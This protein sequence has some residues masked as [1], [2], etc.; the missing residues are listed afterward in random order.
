MTV[1]RAAGAVVV[2]SL[3]VAG[4]ARADDAA[5]LQ[6]ILN[7]QVVTTASTTAQRASVAPALSATITSEDLRLYG[8]HTL[9]EA[10]QFFGLG[11]ETADPLRTPDVGSLG[12]LF[13]NDNGKHFLLLVNGH[14]M[15]D[16]LYGA[17]FFD[18][19][20]G[21][22][23]DLID[24]IEI[25]VGPGSVLYGSNAMMGVVNVITKSASDDKGVH[26][27]GEYEPGRTV[28]ASAGTGFTFKLFGAPSELTFAAQY[29]Q[30]FGPK[31]D[32]GL[33]QFP[34]TY[35]GE[36]IPISFGKNL[37]AN[38]WGG[39]VR[40]AY[41]EQTPSALLRLRVGD[42]EVNLQASSYRRGVPYATSGQYVEFD[43]P[44]SYL[45]DRA[46]RLDVRHQATISAL[47]QLTSRLYA[48]SVDHQ[49]RINVPGLLA[50]HAEPWVQ[51]YD[52]GL[53]R[54]AGI[55]ERLSLNWLHDGSLVTLVGVDARLEEASAK[56]D[57]LD[58]DTRA[59]LEATVG[60]IDKH[61]TLVAPYV[62]QTWSPTNWLDLNA[63][64]RLDADSRYDAVLSPRGAIAIRP[65]EKGVLKAD[66]AQAFRAPTWS[67]TSLANYHFAPSGDLRPET[68]RS[69]SG[70]IEQRF[71]TQRVL[72]G[73][74]RSWWSNL[75][76]SVPLSDAER[77]ML[78]NE[79]K[80]PLVVT[81]LS[82]FQNVASIDNYGWNA[83]WEGSSANNDLRF[84]L[85]VTGAF[86]RLNAGAGPQP[87]AVSP[88]LFGNA[89]LAYVFGG[90]VPTPALVVSFM[91]PRP[92]DAAQP[93]GQP[94]PEAPALADLRLTLGGAVP[95]VPGLSYRASGEY[96]TAS[97]GPYTARPT[98]VGI[99]DNPTPD[100][101]PIDQLR[102]FVGLRYDFLGS[103]QASSQGG[104]Q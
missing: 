82:Q 76:Q 36:K 9:A 86:T 104:A 26:V 24:H 50:L 25:I 93:N 68:V 32:F 1:S 7:E 62:Q 74:F 44:D 13:G 87:L 78:Q 30:R 56:E 29:D 97:H 52:V 70:S 46:V 92:A 31:M 101:V 63:G 47:V 27:A 84:G 67:E 96:I 72:F 89:H 23:I 61:A 35:H 38:V 37:P 83:A 19:G 64:A 10:M 55:E 15:N 54:W 91:G 53:A 5:D 33:E 75:I 12:V 99:A 17:A 42:L 94:L 80:L 79:G 51:Y 59:Y 39:S 71:G 58:A 90:Y 22:P 102:F 34:D 6:S 98:L 77:M 69:V 11:V 73:V 3:M 4:Q 40:H 41:F 21:V 14:A 60:H 2:A 8:V 81:A 65:W 45:L 57:T 20:A 28:R 103:A 18:N 48:D 85:N 66:Y 16:P 88:Q 49:S 43:D 95:L 100:F